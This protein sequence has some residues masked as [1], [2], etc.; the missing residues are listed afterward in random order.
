[1]FLGLLGFKLLLVAVAGYLLGSVNTSLVVGKFYGIDVRQYGS[2]NAGATNTLRTLGKAA[3]LMVGAGDVLKGIISCLIGLLL[4]GKVNGD[5]L[6]IMVGGVAAILGHNWPIYFGFKGGKG[7]FTSFAVVMMMDWK[8]GLTLLGIFIIIVV[9]SR[10]VSLG[11]VIGSLLFPVVA[12]MPM[13][14]RSF[15]FVTFGVAVGLLALFRHR[16]NIVRIF[17]GTESKLGS[18]KS[19]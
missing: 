16:G 1:M 9:L 15:T 6:G 18:K 4:I 7:I 19:T 3:A 10:Y 14:K 11:S 5:F 8:I 2:R 13:F 17:N 12:V